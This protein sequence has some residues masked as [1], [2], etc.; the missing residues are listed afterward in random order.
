MP[1]KFGL[2]FEVRDGES[3]ATENGMVQDD[4]VVGRGSAWCAREVSREKSES[5]TEQD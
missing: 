1:R 5:D 2:Y 3:E 4:R